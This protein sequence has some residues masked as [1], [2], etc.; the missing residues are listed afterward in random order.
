MLHYD[1]QH[2]SSSTLLILRTNCITTASGIVTTETLILTLLYIYPCNVNSDDF[3]FLLF[4]DLSREH[5]TT[6]DIT[7]FKRLPVGIHVLEFRN[8]CHNYLRM[9]YRF[10]S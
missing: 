10:D 9:E 1:P 4:N 2:V 3:M 7:E 5:L 8:L 6:L